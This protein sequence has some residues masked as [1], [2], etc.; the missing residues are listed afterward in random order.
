MSLPLLLYLERNL[1]PVGLIV[2]R[3]NLAD[4]NCFRSSEIG[5]CTILRAGTR[6]DSTCEK[7]RGYERK[8]ETW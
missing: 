4:K 7:R 1:H 3:N 6:E 2:V 5:S 8:N